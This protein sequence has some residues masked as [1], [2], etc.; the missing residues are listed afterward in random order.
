[1]QSHKCKT[2]YVYPNKKREIYKAITKM[3]AV[4]TS[5]SQTLKIFL[6]SH[7]HLCIVSFFGR[8]NTISFS[9]NIII[10]TI[11]IT[12]AIKRFKKYS[13]AWHLG[14]AGEMASTGTLP[15]EAS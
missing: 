2:T 5:Q 12:K 6:I 3:L 15:Q 11:I 9:V 8:M 10:V 7:E 13:I 1:M 14:N 4:V